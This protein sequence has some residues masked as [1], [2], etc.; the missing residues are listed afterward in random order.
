MFL[1]LQYSVLPS[2][3]LVTCSVIRFV[4]IGNYIKKNNN[5]VI[6]IGKTSLLEA[7]ERLSDVTEVEEVSKFTCG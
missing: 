3:I 5:C 6:M 2:F 1:N 7:I 4:Y